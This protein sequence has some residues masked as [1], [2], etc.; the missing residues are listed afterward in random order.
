MSEFLLYYKRPDPTTWVYMSSFLTIGLYFVFHRFWSV[1]NL[2]IV[3][4]ILLAPGLL[5]VHEGRRRQLRELESDQLAA[6]SHQ[7]DRRES[8][9]PTTQRHPF[10]STKGQLDDQSSLRD[11]SGENSR[12]ASFDSRPTMLIR[13]QADPES[14]N[15]TEAETDVD[16]SGDPKSNPASVP[17]SDSNKPETVTEE[18][19]QVTVEPTLQEETNSPLLTD[20]NALDRHLEAT[21]MEKDPMESA[22]AYSARQLQRSGFILLFFV[23][24]MILVRLMIDP[25]MVRRPLLDPNLTTGGLYFISI[26]LFIFMMGNVVT[27]TPRMQ[28][29]QGPELGPGYALMHKLPTITTRP[30]STALGGEEPATPDE[31]DLS[32]QG[33]TLVAKIM[34]IMAHLA[35]VSG[36]VLI[37]NRH[38][39]N[40]R[41]GVGCATLYLIMPY[42]AQMTGRVDHALPAA[43]LLWAILTYRK[44]AVAGVFIGLAAGLVYYPLFLLPLWCSFYWRRGVR[45]FAA[46]VIV[47]LTILMA[48]LTFGGTET[49][50]DHLLR[51]FGL[52]KPTMTP[53]G[54]WGLGWDPVYRLPVIV[55]F[56]ILCFFFASWPSPKNLGTLISC[57]A[58]VMVAAQFWHGYGGGL[59]IAWFLPLLLLTIFRPNLQDRVAL[60]VVRASG[61]GVPLEAPAS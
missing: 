36:I 37:G 3:L 21:S 59:Y 57:S 32:A 53:R 11:S 42:T 54:I 58:A 17:D 31:L 10:S 51:M 44:P 35:I 45:R 19:P 25:M 6:R 12:Y 1:R 27:S 26:S 14:E 13:S 30:V 48:L 2:D 40:L 61:G 34:A 39:D 52:F 28:V 29:W 38:F 33:W 8:D 60:K 46:A 9:H 18:A 4:L 20:P 16:D 55:A 5:M 50:V 43:L 7:A 41:A 15:T 49:L 24:F 23:E 22:A 56:L 47:T